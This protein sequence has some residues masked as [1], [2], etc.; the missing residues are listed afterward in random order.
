LSFESF[1]GLNSLIEIS[2]ELSVVDKSTLST[3]FKGLESLQRIGEDLKV[4]SSPFSAD[5][6]AFKNFEG[7]ENLQIVGGKVILDDTEQIE[8]FQ[9]LEKLESTRSLELFRN[10]GLV[11]FS[12]LSSLNYCRSINVQDNLLLDNCVGLENVDT[13]GTLR[14]VSNPSLVDFEGL[15]N[16]N[17]LDGGIIIVENEALAD[18]SQLGNI[19]EIKGYI[20][21]DGNSSLTTLKGLENIDPV[22]ISTTFDFPNLTITNNSKLSTCEVQSICNFL[23][24][25]NQSFNIA[26]NMEGCNSS[27]EIK[28]KCALLIDL[29]MDGYFS[30]NDC[31]DNNAAINPGAEEVPNNDVDEDCDGEALQVDEDMDGFNSDEDCDD[32]NPSINPDAVEIVNNGIDEN[33][34]GADLTSSIDDE[35]NKVI[36]VYPNPA[37]EILFV[38]NFESQSFTVEIFDLQGML[39]LSSSNSSQ[40]DIGEVNSGIYL[41]KIWTKGKDKPVVQKLSVIK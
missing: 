6:A 19:R 32:T 33:C 21:I 15:T 8:N 20:R 26:S 14:I 10:V 24:L 36:R 38:R 12:G 29:D 34:D 25:E 2:G 35:H 23:N 22:S 39:L 9:G 37:S 3:N 17:R 30:D 16:L 18:L 13:I 5:L 28:N 41:L 31:D 1:T 11:N 27:E 40:I 7:L 4:Y